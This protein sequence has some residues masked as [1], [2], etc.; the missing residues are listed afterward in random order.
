[1]AAYELLNQYFEEEGMPVILSKSMNMIQG[2]T[3]KEVRKDEEGIKIMHLL[4]HNLSWF[5]KCKEA[6]IK[7][8]I[9]FPKQED[10]LTFN[11][12]PGTLF[13]GG[14]KQI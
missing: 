1:M 14:R 2:Y 4:G 10:N 13:A 6:V 3:P 5:L 11:I 9:S 8:G 12:V 7:A